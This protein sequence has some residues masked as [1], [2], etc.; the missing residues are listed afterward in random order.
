MSAENAVQ[1]E[2]PNPEFGT[3]SNQ[4]IPNSAFRVPP[5]RQWLWPIIEIAITLAVIIAVGWQFSVLLSSEALWKQTVHWHWGWIAA[6][7]AAYL[8]G[9]SSSAF[10]WYW[11][12]Q[13][14]GQTPPSI[15]ATS[16][17]YY[18]GQLGRYV[19]G[20]VLGV[21]WRSR[22]L[23]GPG[24]HGGMAALTVVYESLTTLASGALL[25]GLILGL[26]GLNEGDV[27]W[28]AWLLVAL[29]G[30]PILPGIFNRLVDRLTRKI[31]EDPTKPI[32]RVR[33]QTLMLGLFITAIGWLFQG[34]SLLFLS[35]AV[36]PGAMPWTLMALLRCTAYAALAYVAGFVVIAVPGGL[37]VREFFLQRFLTTELGAVLGAESAGAS[38]VLALLLRLIWTTADVGAALVCWPLKRRSD[39]ETG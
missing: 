10:Y 5:Q 34:A 35:E 18:I 32:P 9:L 21:V 1:C 13:A 4:A 25:A 17:A 23:R 33:A 24:V 30:L 3:L 16:R 12:L 20:K 28:K 7:I 38:V 39:K 14:L 31:R 36:F 29:V 2:M 11:L 19:P 37:G 27:Q 15:L 22:L 6:S 26:E 8:I